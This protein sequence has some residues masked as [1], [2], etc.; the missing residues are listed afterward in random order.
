MELGDQGT[1]RRRT[2][3]RSAPTAVGRSRRAAA[4]CRPTRARR[5]ATKTT[6]TGKRRRVLT[7]ASYPR[8]GSDREGRARESAGERTGSIRRDGPRRPGHVWSRG[9]GRRARRRPSRQAD[10]RAPTPGQAGP[11]PQ[12]PRPSRWAGRS[13]CA[14]CVS[15]RTPVTPRSSSS[16][17]SRPGSGTPREVGDPHTLSEGGGRGYAERLLEQFRQV[18][19]TSSTLEVAATPSG[20]SRMGD[21]GAAWRSTASHTVARMLE[22]D[23]FA[24]RY[25]GE[26]ADHR[27]MEFLYPLFQGYDSV[28]VEA[29]VELGGTDQL[30]NLLVGRELQ[31]QRRPGSAGGADDAA[32]RG[33][34][35]RAEDEP[36]RSATTWGSPN[37]R[38]SSSAS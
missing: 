12:R 29:D 7:P 10:A 16:G 6:P 26:P 3:R 5:A 4:G 25:Q 13:C 18:I 24:N 38:T 21:G 37:R 20:S 17:I 30:F 28:A 14:S 32:A 34:R 35:R 33:A 19:L 2:G 1:V 23:D 9:G 15:S 22:R 11:R 27:S 36:S 31:R 8:V